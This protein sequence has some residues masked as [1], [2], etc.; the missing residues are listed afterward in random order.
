MF[1]YGGKEVTMSRK[2]M[3][4]C[5]VEVGTATPSPVRF[6]WGVRWY[7]VVD[8]LATWVEAAPWWRQLTRRNSAEAPPAGVRPIEQEVWRV[9]AVTGRQHYRSSVVVVPGVYDLIHEPGSQ[10]WWLARVWD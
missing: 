9:A 1:D 8:V 2:H 6:R 10:R 7:R 3:Q 4:Q 5:R